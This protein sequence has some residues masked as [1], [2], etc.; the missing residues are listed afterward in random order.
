M[1]VAIKSKVLQPALRSACAAICAFLFLSS[2]AQ[3]AP[4][5]LGLHLSPCTQGHSKVA[6]QCGTFGVYE[7]RGARSGRILELQVVVLRA[8][9]PSH[10]AIAQIAGG[11]GE[12]TVFFAPLIADRVFGKE[13]FALRDKYDVLFVDNRGMGGSNPFKCDFT[14]DASPGEYFKQLFPDRAVTACRARTVTTHG[15]G[16]YNTNNAVDD[17]DDVRAALGI[18]KLVLNGGSYGTFFSLVYVR[19]HPEHVESAVLSGVVA[20]HFW[21]LPGAPA[22]AQTAMD[23][24]KIKCKHDALCDAHFPRFAEHFDALVLRFDRGPIVVPVLNAATKRVERVA[25]SKEVFVDHLR[26][27]LYDPGSAS[28][29]PFII[30]RAYYKDYAPL[31]QVLNVVSRALGSQLDMGALLSYSCGDEMPFIDDAGLQKEAAH[32]FA[33]DLRVRAERRA[34]SLWNVPAMPASFNDIVHSNVPVLMINGSDDPATPPRYAGL[35]L[36]Y[37]PN[38][39]QVLVQGAGHAP[40]TPCT[41]ALIEQFVRASSAKGLDLNK[42]RAALTLPRFDLSLKGWPKL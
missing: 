7:D 18:P 41:S 2:L 9:H 17:L 12:G 25:L 3:A 21:A 28:S 34:C 27:V 26:Q 36:R 14:P 15:F 31:A 42:C 38:G 16:L 5:Q 40:D 22:G 35:A 1:N 4:Q 37:L 39:R 19:R 23:D 24:L 11:P 13:V 8:K 29:V 32:S 33:G 10:R 6:A 20:P 30:E